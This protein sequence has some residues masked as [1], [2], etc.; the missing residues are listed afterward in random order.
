MNLKGLNTFTYNVL[1]YVVFS[2]LYCILKLTSADSSV[3]FN[4]AEGEG[5]V[6]YF[7]LWYYSLVTQ[8]TV[9]YGDIYP[10][11]IIAK[12]IAM[13]HIV[14]FVWGNIAIGFN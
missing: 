11:S 7:N 3:H 6:G 4:G 14:L 13:A 8:S 1:L 2:I 10:V 5:S 9:G 12:V